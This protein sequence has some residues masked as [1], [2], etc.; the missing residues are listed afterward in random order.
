MQMRLT[1]AAARKKPKI[2]SK[3]GEIN[4]TA[5]TATTIQSDFFIS[6]PY[7]HD[8]DDDVDRMMDQAMLYFRI[9]DNKIKRKYVIPVTSFT[10]KNKKQSDNFFKR[11]FKLIKSLIGLK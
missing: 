2:N 11:L 1:M 7:N 8:D 5:H 3:T 4:L 10:K 9:D 6:S